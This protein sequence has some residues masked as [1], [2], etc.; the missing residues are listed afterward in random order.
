MRHRFFE[1]AFTDGVRL[2]Q[3]RHG[4]RAA[5]AALTPRKAGSRTDEGL[6][7][8]EID[9]I[10]VRESFYLGTV[11]E[12]GWPHVQ[13]RG[14]PLGFVRTLG[15]KTLGWADFSGNRQYVSIGNAASN[16]RVALFFMDYPN[17]QRLKVLGR[18]TTIEIAERP[19][20]QVELELAG[21]GAR[22]EHAILID[23]EAFDWNCP[24]H[25]SPRFTKNE[26]EKLVAPLRD[27]IE[28][29]ERLLSRA[30][31]NQ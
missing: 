11:S 14:G 18:M 30:L 4:S 1:T 10:S 16:D 5:Y 27:R 22:T 25:I 26:V 20:L 6:G 2:E 23:V 9:F 13:H 17:R 24:Q 28:D 29:L 7:S 8:D 3:E 19:E 21:Y 12:T 31:A 15:R